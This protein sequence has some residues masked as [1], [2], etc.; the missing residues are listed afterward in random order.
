MHRALSGL[1]T[2]GAADILTAM[3]ARVT[4]GSATAG[5]T[6][7]ASAASPSAFVSPSPASICGESSTMQCS[8]QHRLNPTQHHY[9]PSPLPYLRTS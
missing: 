6:K 2:V 8:I 5:C 3:L 1:Y 4:R 7:Y 9:A